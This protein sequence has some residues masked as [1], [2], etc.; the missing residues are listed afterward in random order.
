MGRDVTFNTGQFLRLR[1]LV[2]NSPSTTVAEDAVLQPLFRK[3]TLTDVEK[4]ACVY[5]ERGDG[6]VEYRNDTPVERHLSTQ[7]VR[8]LV[9]VVWRPPAGLEWKVIDWEIK[10]A[11]LTELGETISALDEGDD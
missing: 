8:A 3:L 9:S 2:A 4:E 10:C 6:F 5:R 1:G 7:Q 11:I